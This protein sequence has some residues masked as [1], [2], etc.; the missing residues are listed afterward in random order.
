MKVFGTA[1]GLP[2][3]LRRRPLVEF[4]PPERGHPRALF[5]GQPITFVRQA[6]QCTQQKIGRLAVEPGDRDQPSEIDQVMN[7]QALFFAVLAHLFSAAS[8]V[9]HV[10]SGRNT[11]RTFASGT[12]P[13]YR[14]SQLRILLKPNSQTSPAPTRRAPDGTCISD[15]PALSR[16]AVR[17]FGNFTPLT[18][19]QPGSSSTASPDNAPITF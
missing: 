6:H 12:G 16:A 2:R 18:A 14:A 8:A 9:H 1:P 10:T 5:G 13:K 17:L 4:L 11:P 7:P 19:T 15:R 3:S